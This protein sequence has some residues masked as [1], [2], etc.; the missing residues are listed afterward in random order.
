M[1]KS[2]PVENHSF[3]QLYSYA[4]AFIILKVEEGRKDK[5]REGRLEGRSYREEREGERDRELERRY[6]QS[7]AHF[8]S[9]ASNFIS[10]CQ[11]HISLVLKYKLIVKKST[12]SRV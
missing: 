7:I 2:L 4:N 3:Q 5:G 6:Q 8:L 1:A 10:S 11:T 9:T 12:G